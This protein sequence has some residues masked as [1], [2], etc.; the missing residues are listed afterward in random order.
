[1]R[2]R[3]R[4]VALVAADL[5]AAEEAI[6]AKLG[7]QLCFRDPG[8]ATFGLANALYPIGDKLLEVVSPT[9]LG[10]TAGRLI[11]KRGGDGGYMVILEVDD[12]SNL[13]SRFE[14]TGVRV[15]YEAVADGIVGLHLHPRDVGGAILS[16]D[17]TD[18][19]GTWPWAGPT[20]RDHVCTDVVSDIIAVEIGADDPLAMAN[21]WGEVLGRRPAGTDIA[22]D[23]GTIR[24]VPAGPRGEGV[25]GLELRSSDP[26]QSSEIDLCEC[27]IRLVP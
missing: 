12:L 14:S 18:E 2:M 6:E 13:R 22:L 27:R 3:L 15:V 24:F 4:Q 17:E 7:V 25:D 11:D 20:W 19:W 8:V 1:M 26:G 5:A 23:E 9:R 16:V 10:T 21:R